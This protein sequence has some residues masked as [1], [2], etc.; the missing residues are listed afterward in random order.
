L[1]ANGQRLVS[2]ITIEAVNELGI[3]EG[4]AVVAVVKASDVMIAIEE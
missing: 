2:S 3:S 4:T 1:D